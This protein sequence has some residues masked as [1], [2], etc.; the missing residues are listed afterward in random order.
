MSANQRPLCC[1]FPAARADHRRQG[2]GRNPASPQALWVAVRQAALAPSRHAVPAG[3]GECIIAR[4]AKEMLMTAGH[5]YHPKRGTCIARYTDA[6]EVFDCCRD[7]R[8]IGTLR[9]NTIY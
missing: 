9:S 7:G 3:K 5:L 6:F 2:D 1:A 4:F 8:Q